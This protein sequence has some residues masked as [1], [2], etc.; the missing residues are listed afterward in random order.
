MAKVVA[1]QQQVIV[2][3][4]WVKIKIVYI[5]LGAGLLWWVLTSILRHYIIEPLACSDLNTAATCVNSFGVSG[6]IATV[7][8]AI[9]GAYILVRAVQPRPIVIAIATAV[10]LW[11]LAAFLSGLAWWETAF[12]ALSFYAATYALFSLVARVQNTLLSMVSAAVVV[13]VIRLLLIL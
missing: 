4:W 13:I 5:G 12:W 3:P 11:D 10:L 7:L 6:S 8:V 9:I 2:E 1:S